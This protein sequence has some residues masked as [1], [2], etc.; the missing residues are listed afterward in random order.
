[1]RRVFG[2]AA[3]H[4]NAEGEEAMTTNPNVLSTRSIA[5]AAIVAVA[6]GTS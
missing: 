6:L 1:M 2:A 3:L 4:G 5:I